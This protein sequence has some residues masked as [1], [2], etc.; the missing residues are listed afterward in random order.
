MSEAFC[1]KQKKQSC[2]SL[3]GYILTAPEY[4]VMD[5]ASQLRN[6]VVSEGAGGVSEDN[7]SIY[8]KAPSTLLREFS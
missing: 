5:L 4:V 6:D 1:G 8:Q 2:H 7:A 3:I